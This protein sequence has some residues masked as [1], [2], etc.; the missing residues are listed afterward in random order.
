MSEVEK[1]AAITTTAAETKRKWLWRGIALAIA[2]IIVAVIIAVVVVVVQRNQREAD[3]DTDASINTA[4]NGQSSE[5]Q[6][7]I[8]NVGDLH[9]LSRYSNLTLME[10][11]QDDDLYTNP[12]HK[13]YVIGDIHG[14]LPE[15]NQL[16]SKLH[17]NHD[18][19]DRIILAGDLVARGPDSVGVIRRA[20][21]LKALCVRGNHDDKVIRLKTYIRSG[22]TVS[23]Q[24]IIPEGPVI[25]PLEYDNYHM[26][27]AQYV[28]LLYYISVYYY[29]YYKKKRR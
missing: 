29:Y 10:T 4:A 23:R 8:S 2:A 14:S 13:L 24:G 6:S 27:I 3:N 26:A 19:G 28:I 20:N 22:H 17:Y 12:D 9:A 18:A 15:F 16:I 25:D 21:E 1:A 5:D 11:M 7:N